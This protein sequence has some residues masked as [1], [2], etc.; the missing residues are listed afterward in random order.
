MMGLHNAGT[1][2]LDVSFEAQSYAELFTVTPALCQIE[3][4]GY[5]SVSVTF[6]APISAT[7]AV[8][9]R[10]VACVFC[11]IIGPVWAPGL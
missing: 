7:A 4:G 9:Q 6:E 5:A 11:D 8:Y 1:I 10:F 3:P 2:V